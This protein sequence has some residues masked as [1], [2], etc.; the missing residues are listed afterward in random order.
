MKYMMFVVSDPQPDSSPDES[1]IDLWV[2]PLD[3]SGKRVIGEVLAP[4]AESTVVR[5]RGGKVLTTRG[6]FAETSEVI[7]GFDILEVADLDEAIDIASRH[8][9]ARNG[10]IE[11]RAFAPWDE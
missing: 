11:L 1:D 10:Q 9:M 2:D 6:P 7:L 4:P 5:V 3:A 8:P